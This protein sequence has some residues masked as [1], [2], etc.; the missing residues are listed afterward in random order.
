MRLSWRSALAVV[1]SVAAVGVISLPRA[2]AAAPPYEPDP[3]AVGA[4]SFYNASGVQITSGSINDRPIAAYVV[5]SDAIRSADATAALLTAQPNPALSDPVSWNVDELSAFTHYPL[6]TG[7]ANIKTLSLTHPVV[8]G[9]STDLSLANFIAEFPNASGTL[10]NLYQFRV[11][12]ADASGAETT[13]YLS[14]DVKVSGNTWTQVY[15]DPALTTTTT[16]LVAAPSPA[17]V[18]QKVTLTATVAPAGAAGSVQFRDGSTNIGTPIVVNG[19]GV[20][21]TS[22]KTLNQAVHQLFAVFT[23]SA[24][25]TFAASTGSVSEAVGLTG[26]GSITGALSGKI[27]FSPALT[28]TPSAGTVKYT[29]TATLGAVTGST[30]QGTGTITGASIKATVTLPAGTTCNSYTSGGFVRGA[31][32]ITYTTVGGPVGKTTLT[33]SSSVSTVPTPYTVTLASPTVTGSFATPSGSASHGTLV[34]DQTKPAV[35]T[36]CAGAGL[37]SLGFTGKKGTS[38]LT[39]G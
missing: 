21:T 39:I 33:F 30:G 35:T 16:A 13:A 37:K 8:T 29:F 26:T 9:A 27:A 36:S 34:L 32:A 7:P 14:G 25:A 10:A 18:G 24:T 31:S 3:N 1:V 38:T 19:G 20:A 12:T 5:G 22:T 23:P 28:N 4:L 11:K 2:E 6:T 17:T 15:P